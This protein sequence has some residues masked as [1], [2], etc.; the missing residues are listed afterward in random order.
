MTPIFELSSRLFP[1]SDA[2]GC[3]NQQNHAL[4]SGLIIG[5]AA[6]PQKRAVKWGRP[7]SGGS[8]KTVG[9][10]FRFGNGPEWSLKEAASH[11]YIHL[12][13]VSNFNLR[14]LWGGPYHMLVHVLMKLGSICVPVSPLWWTNFEIHKHMAGSLATAKQWHLLANRVWTVGNDIS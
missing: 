3:E 10:D 5:S 12:N 7:R 6:A 4:R 14:V 11:E 2:R 9:N 1:S 13:Y 8:R